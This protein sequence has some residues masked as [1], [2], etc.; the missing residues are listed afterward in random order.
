MEPDILVGVKLPHAVIV[1]GDGGVSSGAVT[2]NIEWTLES[3][4]QSVPRGGS[5]FN[6]FDFRVKFPH[7]K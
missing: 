7:K 5:T 4:T 6:L 2:S 1:G 3:L